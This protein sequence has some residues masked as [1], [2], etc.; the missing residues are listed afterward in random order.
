MKFNVLTTY[1]GPNSGNN[2]V[3][4]PSNESLLVFSQKTGE[5]LVK[6]TVLNGFM[7]HADTIR[8]A[9]IFNHL[10]NDTAPNFERGVIEVW[11]KEVLK[12]FQI[13][14]V[15]LGYHEWVL[16]LIEKY[17]LTY[18]EVN[19]IINCLLKDTSNAEAQSKG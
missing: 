7:S 1:M 19:A 8:F 2:Y 10:P 9:C 18:T 15:R 3:Y 14:A 12:G 13:E 16:N 17:N 6:C 11:K 4:L 5:L